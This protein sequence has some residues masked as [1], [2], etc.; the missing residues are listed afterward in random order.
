MTMWALDHCLAQL[1][2]YRSMRLFHTT[3]LVQTMFSIRGNTMWSNQALW[4]SPD[5][6][7]R[8]KYDNSTNYVVCIYYVASEYYMDRADAVVNPDYG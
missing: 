6:V 8:P 1:S 2:N 7:I 3:W 5:Y 4:L